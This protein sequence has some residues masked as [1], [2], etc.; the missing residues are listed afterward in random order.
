MKHSRVLTENEIIA[1]LR[2]STI[3]C[4]LVE[5]ADDMSVFR[6][7]EESVQISVFSCGG[8]STLLKVFER[9][10]EIGNVRCAFFC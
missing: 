3:D 4:L 5:G 7:L 9:R 2:H 10:D 6:L 8:R 1:S